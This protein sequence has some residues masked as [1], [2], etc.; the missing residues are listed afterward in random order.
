MRECSGN[1]MRI[2]IMF[3]NLESRILVYT[4]ILTIPNVISMSGENY[5]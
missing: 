2:G 1:L 4:E 3:I 5:K